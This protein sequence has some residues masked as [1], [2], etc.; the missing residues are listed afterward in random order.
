MGFA[1]ENQ[2]V[3][4]GGGAFLTGADKNE[5]MENGI[6]FPIIGVERRSNPFEDDSEQYLV[7]IILED[8]EADDGEA[9]KILSYTVGA[10]ESRDRLCERMATWLDDSSNDPPLAKL[11]K[12]GRSQI[13]VVLTEEEVAEYEAGGSTKPKP[14]AKAKPKP[15][16]AKPAAK[17]TTAKRTTAA[18][19]TTAKK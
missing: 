17:R 15:A 10:V 11:N 19:K 1:E 7:R 16:A 13:L 5:L 4:G 12:V 14:A 2:D 8:D 3:M 9:E 18:K 6:V